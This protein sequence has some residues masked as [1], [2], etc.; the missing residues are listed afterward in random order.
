MAKLIKAYKDNFTIVDNDIF[1]DERLSLKELG[2][3]CQ[4]LS[5]PNDWNFSVAGLST[6]HKDGEDSIKAGIK[7]LEEYGYLTRR[8]SRDTSGLYTGNDYLIYQNP[9]DNPDFNAPDQT[10]QNDGNSPLGE[11][12]LV[13]NPPEENPLVDK[14]LTDKP[15]V[16]NQPQYSTKRIK[17][18]KINEY[19]TEGT[20]LSDLKEKMNTWSEDDFYSHLNKKQYDAFIELLHRSIRGEIH[21]SK[22]SLFVFFK[23]MMAG[24][25]KDAQGKPINN[26]VNYV[27]TV[28]NAISEENKTDEESHRE[29]I[30][31]VYDDSNNPPF[32]EEKYNRIM[33]ERNKKED[34]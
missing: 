16:D 17:K 3:L 34:E 9:L 21:S 24:G 26:I 15:L 14:P 23:K 30:I 12:P 22:E 2:L 1:K 11:N 20:D 8:R 19:V 5:L 4:L 13:D 27:T 25:W 33:M 31:P 28:F 7:K 18:E 6:L 29:D 32:D 10:T